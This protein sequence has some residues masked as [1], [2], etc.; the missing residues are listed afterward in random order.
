MAYGKNKTL[1]EFRINGNGNLKRIIQKKQKFL[2]IIANA[3]LLDGAET[4]KRKRECHAAERRALKKHIV[5][6]APGFARSEVYQR[7]D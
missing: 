1:I 6:S 4:L 7:L 2:D 5:G 3:K